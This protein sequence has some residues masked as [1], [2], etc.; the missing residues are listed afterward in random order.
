MTQIMPKVKLLTRR[1]PTFL[2]KIY[3]PFVLQ[4]LWVTI[5]H[6][7][8]HFLGFRKM[9]T[10]E[11]PE[12]PKPI[13]E[14]YRAEHRLMKR[15]DE[16]VRCT[17]CMLCATACPAYCIEIVATESPDPQIEKYPKI[18]NINLLRCVFCGLCVE[19]CPVDAIRM[20]TKKIDMAGFTREEFILDIDYLLENHPEGMSPYSI[21]P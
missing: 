9:L 8:S 16:T 10:Y 3:L 4:G 14:G 5:R 13:P 7:L 21:A 20:D 2:E 11:Y 15:S 12:Q 19:A 1:P 6:F 17:S 18:F